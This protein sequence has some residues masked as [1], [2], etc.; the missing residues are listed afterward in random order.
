MNFNVCCFNDRIIILLEAPTYFKFVRETDVNKISFNQSLNIFPNFFQYIANDLEQLYRSC[1]VVAIL[2]H[3]DTTMM[4]NFPNGTKKTI[5]Y[6]TYYTTMDDCIIDNIFYDELIHHLVGKMKMSAYVAQVFLQSLRQG[7]NKPD[8]RID[9]LVD[10][11][12]I[13]THH[14]NLADIRRR[15]LNLSQEQKRCIE[16][17]VAKNSTFNAILPNMLLLNVTNCI[18]QESLSIKYADNKMDT[19]DIEIHENSISSPPPPPS[20]SSSLSSFSKNGKT[21]KQRE[22]RQI[23]N[24]ITNDT[25]ENTISETNKRKTKITKKS[26]QNIVVDE[27]FEQLPRMDIDDDDDDDAAAANDDNINLETTTATTNVQSAAAAVTTT[28][29]KLNFQTYIKDME[30]QQHWYYCSYG[31]VVIVEAKILMSTF[32]NLIM[33]NIVLAFIVKSIEVDQLDIFLYID[34]E[35]FN[36]FSKIHIR[37]KILQYKI[38]NRNYYIDTREITISYNIDMRIPIL[39]STAPLVIANTKTLKET[40][41]SKIKLIQLYL[42]VCEQ[43]LHRILNDWK[44]I[45]KILR[46]IISP[47]NSQAVFHHI[48]VYIND[49][50]TDFLYGYLPEHGMD[51]QPCKCTTF[52]TTNTVA[53]TTD[54]GDDVGDHDMINTTVTTLPHSQK[55]WYIRPCIEILFH[56]HF[57]WTMLKIHADF[58][59]RPTATNIFQ[60]YDIYEGGKLKIAQ[61]LETKIFKATIENMTTF[62][63]FNETNILYPFH[64]SGH[65]ELYIYTLIKMTRI[66]YRCIVLPLTKL[67]KFTTKNLLPSKYILTYAFIDDPLTPTTSVRGPQST[68]NLKSIES[69]ERKFDTKVINVTMLMNSFNLCGSESIE[70]TIK[71]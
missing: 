8:T 29:N 54:D 44:C 62:K 48:L 23:H 56:T 32:N 67:E 46:T 64:A 28:T 66:V 34:K 2:Y 17:L 1:Q 10:N 18:Q 37:G 21:K 47:F 51:N 60:L 15:V 61:L 31:S 41:R 3:I 38:C 11:Y 16:T 59:R 50:D 69:L 49:S 35:K 13:Q 55:L 30:L 58:L 5:T 19:N 45:C 53:T 20:S 65:E 7:F 39:Y 63:F 70:N 57:D 36:Q 40:F 52:S 71:I 43:S 9:A 24:T 27:T 42:I 6:Y 68:R 26:D 33:K 22:K 14:D 12:N 25:W 4:N